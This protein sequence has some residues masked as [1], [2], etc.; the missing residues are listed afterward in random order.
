MEK[1]DISNSIT[2]NNL[3]K[4]TASS[5]NNNELLLCATPIQ[6]SLTLFHYLGSPTSIWIYQG[7]IYPVHPHAQTQ[8][9]RGG[10]TTIIPLEIIVQ[11]G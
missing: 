7:E 10:R 1:I 9:E 4:Y 8:T 5:K 6:G 2:L 3:N 11:N